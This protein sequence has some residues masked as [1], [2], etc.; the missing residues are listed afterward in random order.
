MTRGVR[1]LLGT[2]P[3]PLMNQPYPPFKHDHSNRPPPGVGQ[4][5]QHYRPQYQPSQ[6]SSYTIP[7][8][9][10]NQQDQPGSSSFSNFT[11]IPTEYF[12]TANFGTVAIPP[13]GTGNTN[14]TGDTGTGT[15]PSNLSRSMISD[16]RFTVPGDDAD[17]DRLGDLDLPPDFDDDLDI[18]DDSHSQGNMD[19]TTQDIP[20]ERASTQQPS[21]IK[22]GS[23]MSNA[24]LQAYEEE[25]R[26][27]KQ[28]LA[29][30]NDLV[31]F[32]F[33][34]ILLSA[35]SNMKLPFLF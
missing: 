12:N 20:M 19:F 22:S 26:L 3:V 21:N 5:S 28:Q 14:T 24:A 2:P 34:S 27:L 16:P 15:G 25:L 6:S 33:E 8:Q 30:V 31:M 13:P 10:S 35:L 23:S 17:M 4:I 32:M 29:E 9:A 1:P 18:K 7:S 11:D